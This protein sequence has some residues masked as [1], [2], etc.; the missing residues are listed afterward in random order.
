M[1]KRGP[2]PR[3]DAKE[4]RAKSVR[5][6]M[7]RYRQ[8]HRN[9]ISARTAARRERNRERERKLAHLTTTELFV[10][11]KAGLAQPL[12]VWMDANG[13]LHREDTRSAEEVIRDYVAGASRARE[14]KHGD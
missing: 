12:V 13:T 4:R 11:N 10:T 3:P 6:A 8:A 7:K 2:K 5:A 14:E 1:G 9:E